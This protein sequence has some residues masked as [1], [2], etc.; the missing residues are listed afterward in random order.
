MTQIKLLDGK[1]ISFYKSI[2]GLDLV[3]KISK[4]LEKA[5]LIMEV[6]G[7]LK[8]L[9]Y[10]IKNN[11]KTKKFTISGNGKQVRDVLHAS[12]VVNL[13]FKAVENIEK[14][15]GNVFNIG[16]GIENSLSLLELFKLLESTLDI[17]MNFDQLPFRD[18]DQLVFIANNGK[19]KKIIS[20]L[21]VQ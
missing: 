13:Y 5:A 20:E 6:D 1:K 4:S 17:K 14:S 21:M 2:N 12:D 10:E 8:D 18:S 16:G 15:K 3:K 19:A 7:E 9:S 11:S